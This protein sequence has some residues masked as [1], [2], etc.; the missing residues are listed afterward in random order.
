MNNRASPTPSDGLIAALETIADEGP[1][2]HCMD[3]SVIQGHMRQAAEALRS[4]R[5]EKQTATP[6]DGRLSWCQCGGRLQCL[7][8][9]IEIGVR[10]DFGTQGVEY[11]KS[12][13]SALSEKERTADERLA[14]HLDAEHRAHQVVTD[15]A[16]YRFLR[17]YPYTDGWSGVPRYEVSVCV[18]GIGTILRG[19]KLDEQVD[20][21]MNAKRMEIANG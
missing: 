16:R 21:E 13:L 14:D 2:I 9:M 11:L 19:A 7:G 15:A 20:M 4:V 10:R 3:W 6:L 18:K 12:A 5:S 8:C 1:L 17:D